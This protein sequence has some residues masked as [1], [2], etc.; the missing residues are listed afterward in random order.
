MPVAVQGRFCCLAA[1]KKR[2]RPTW[3]RPRFYARVYNCSQTRRASPPASQ[4]IYFDFRK[5]LRLFYCDYCA[6][7]LGS[8]EIYDTGCT[9]APLRC[10]GRGEKKKEA[11]VGV[12]PTMA[13]LQSMMNTY[14][15]STHYPNTHFQRENAKRN[16]ANPLSKR[17]RHN[18]TGNTG[19]NGWLV[20]SRTIGCGYG[21]DR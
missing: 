14:S 15:V 19:G 7:R 11:P 21:R 6:E 12:G 18:R 2:N 13:D 20:A 1:V 4:F 5:I 3:G 17:A 16:N 8:P 10:F 9:P